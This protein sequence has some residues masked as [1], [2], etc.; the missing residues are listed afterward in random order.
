MRRVLERNF[1]TGAAGTKDA[2][3]LAGGRLRRG[4]VDLRAA[5]EPSPGRQ[6]C[7]LSTVRRSMAYRRSEP[8]PMRTGRV[9]EGPAEM[10]IEV[11][12]I[13]EA[14]GHRYAGNGIVGGL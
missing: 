12:L 10:A 5:P 6:E 13:A 3:E 7:S 9:T 4:S 11:A 8:G 2:P 14:E 1:G